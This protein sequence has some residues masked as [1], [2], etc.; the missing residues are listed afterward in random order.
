MKPFAEKFP[1]TESLKEYLGRT[2]PSKYGMDFYSWCRGLF[3]P[4]NRLPDL[5]Q[6]IFWSHLY[7]AVSQIDKRINI[8]DQ[9]FMSLNEFGKSLK[10]PQINSDH[11][12]AI[13]FNVYL[14]IIKQ[15]ELEDG[16]SDT[17]M[18]KQ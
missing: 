7:F 11:F 14:Y 17:V 2:P 15:K 13:C 6:C 16:N 9:E 5:E 8:P 3:D 1:T 18:E 12:L 10:V 4:L